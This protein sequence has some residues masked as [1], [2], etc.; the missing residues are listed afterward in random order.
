[1]GLLAT[2]FQYLGA[3]SV[4]ILTY[5]VAAFAWLYL[6]PSSLHRY[7]HGKPGTKWSLVTG[8]SDG[9]G[10]GFANALSSEGFNVLLH[11]RNEK[12]LVG[13]KEALQKQYPALQYQIVIA[14]AFDPNADIDNI[15]SVA[16]ALPGKLTVLINNVG[17][18]PLDPMFGAMGQL[19]QPYVDKIINLN[20]RFPTQLTRALIPLFTSNSPSLIMNITSLTALNGLPYLATYSS[21]KAFNYCFSQ[22][23]KAEMAAEGH[24]IEVLGIVV[25]NVISGSNKVDQKGFTCTSLQMAKEALGRVGCGKANVWGWYR[26]ALQGNLMMMLPEFVVQ[27][28]MISVMKQQM[29]AGEK[30]KNQ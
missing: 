18:A 11:G 19:D 12:K 3:A 17:G 30:Q 1:M 22:S 5:K 4:A 15:V 27:P 28:M 25:A 6:R 8:A 29:A 16:R 10:Q 13:V 24:S 23:L 7:H 21:S 26:H 20:A 2:S 14:D 9:I